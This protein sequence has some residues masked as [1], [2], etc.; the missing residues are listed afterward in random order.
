MTT[1]ENSNNNKRIAKNSLLLFIR[2]LFSMAVSLYTTRAILEVLGITDFG[3]YNVVGGVI[4]FFGFL[5]QTMSTTTSRFITTA[6]GKNDLEI[7]HKTFCM[8]MNFHIAITLFTFIIGESIGLWFV[9]NKLI[10]PEERLTA[11]LW[12]YQASVLST[13]VNILNVPYNASIIA[14]ENMGAFAYISIIQVIAKLIIVLVL[15]Y[16]P[17]DRL[18]IFSILTIS[19]SLIIQLI[20]WQYSYRKFKETHFKWIWDKYIWKDMSSFASWNITGDLAYMCNTQGINILLNLFFGPVVNAARGVAVQVESVMIQFIGNFQTAISPQITKSYAAGNIEQTRHLT[21]KASK[22]CF[23]LMMII[24][25]PAFLEIEYV[26]KLWLQKIPTYTVIFAKLTIIMI[27][28]DC[29]SRPLHLAIFAT[30]TVKKYQ[31]IQSSIYLLILP[32]SYILL[33]NLHVTPNV[34]I[35][36]LAL[37][38]FIVLTVRIKLTS[39][40][41]AIPINKYITNVLVPSVQCLILSLILPLVITLSYPESLT[42][43]C[44]TCSISLLISTVIIYTYGLTYDEKQFIKNQIHKIVLKR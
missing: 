34:I 5:N 29:L 27:I 24:A 6:L 7:L 44:L 13:C 17:A 26:L 18:I 21:L 33:K 35:G 39:T 4:V 2:M 38:K 12:L 9:T 43:V 41:I 28:F 40:L 22:F 16:I 31:I 3:I 8:S 19:V 10:I 36:V 32:I 14:H 42:R 30:G 25:I 20:Y 15:P 37:F 11:A 1:I 23:F